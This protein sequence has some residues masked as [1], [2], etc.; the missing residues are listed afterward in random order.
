[1]IDGVDDVKRF[2]LLLVI[3]VGLLPFITY[4]SLCTG[5]WFFSPIFIF[6]YL[7]DA[8]DVVQ[9]S[10]QDQKELFAMLAA[11]LWLG[12]ITFQV[13]DSENHVDVVADEGITIYIF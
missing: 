9:I 3:L 2:N 5:D 1:M 10:R 6:E 7:Q 12:N 8:L 4:F 11:V 13:I